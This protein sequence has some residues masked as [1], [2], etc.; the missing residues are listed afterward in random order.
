[1]KTLILYATKHGAAREVAQ[2]IAKLIDGAALH[3]LKQG[4]V[5]SLAEYDCIII[6]GS[7]YVGM[8]R[9]EAKTFLTQNADALRGKRLGLFLCGM[10]AS[11][12]QTFFK[13]NFPAEILQAAKAASFMG[14]IFDPKKAG[15]MERFIVKVAAKQSEYIDNID[16]EK[17]KK[18]AE[19]MRG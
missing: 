11:E 1:M 2:R 15:I 7:I 9:K 12:E 18:F 5:P 17:I 4:G 13:S 10:Q 16:N 14:G 19:V 8:L 3:D 6:G